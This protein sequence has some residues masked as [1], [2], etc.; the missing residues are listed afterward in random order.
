MTKITC[1]ISGMEFETKDVTLGT[2]NLLKIEFEA[3]L[4]GV[5]YTS[6]LMNE[7]SIKTINLYEEKIITINDEIARKK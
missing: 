2:L 5:K 3:Y 7:I 4:Q 6:K 1:E